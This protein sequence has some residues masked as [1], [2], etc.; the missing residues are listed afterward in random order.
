MCRR[1]IRGIS[2]NER[3]G[4][5]RGR[6]FLRGIG[7]FLSLLWALWFFPSCGFADLRPIGISTSPGDMNE[8]L[9]GE[10]SPVVVQFDTEMD[11]AGVEKAV[12]INS[13]S[14]AMEG[15]FFWEGNR[16]SF[17][18]LPGWKPG[19]RYALSL[20][21]TIY[22]RDGRELRLDR[23]IPFYALSRSAAPALESFD[24][25][26]GASVGT[27]PDEGRL[28]LIF[29]Q[30]MDRRSV[31]E[32]LTLGVG[33]KQ[34]TWLDDD[35]CL[36]VYPS[37]PL[38]AWTVYRWTLSESAL[39][40]MGVPLAK[41]VSAQFTTDFD[42]LIPRV[43]RAFPMVKSGNIW[44]ETGGSLERD[45]GK[46]LGIGI[47]FNKPMDRSSVS[48]AVRLDPALSGRTEILSD[49]SIVFIPGRDPEP[50]T[51]YT[52]I[53]SG[54]TR[55]AFGLKLGEDY[56]VCFVPDIPYLEILA[57]TVYGED[58]ITG[59]GL[60]NGA[61]HQVPVDISGSGVTGV[62]GFVLWFSLP[63][64]AEAKV[65][66]AFRILLDAY[67]P[68]SLISVP[69]LRLARW[70][71]DDRLLMEWDGLEPSIPGQSS[72]YKLFLPGGRNGI[73]AGGSY[74]QEDRFLFFE[75]VDP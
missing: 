19:T 71:S 29:S 66:A 61:S 25:P 30:P 39:S 34:Y 31:E 21:G 57:L 56:R 22:S 50:E 23:Y 28:R 55:D 20:S 12:Q 26:D 8:L 40:R 72:Y 45:L 14:G 7:F 47:E 41:A 15:D 54:D 67:F 51:N 70:L 69:S 32:V 4:K 24:P 42:R 17:I 44:M 58:P 59:G 18:P 2:K 64:T 3:F 73:N 5:L 16:L 43:V 10:Y 9:P 49:V 53:V 65:D 13:E 35:R 48:L 75:A 46:G 11:Q 33:T 74:F 1:R 63:F 36:E 68:G 60:A 27:A 52:L 62:L 37:E 6:D 38:S